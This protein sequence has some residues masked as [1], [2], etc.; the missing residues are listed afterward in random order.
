MI[1][2]IGINVRY[3]NNNDQKCSLVSLKIVEKLG[4]DT[5]VHGTFDGGVELVVRLDGIR[6]IESNQILNLSFPPD[7]LHLFDR[8]IGKRI[9]LS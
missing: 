4:A 1:K 3:I 2:T 7:A 5:I 8:E 9:E 6:E